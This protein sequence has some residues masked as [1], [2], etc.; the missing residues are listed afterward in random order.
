MNH[1]DSGLYLAS[2][3]EYL[4]YAQSEVCLTSVINVSK[5]LQSL[6]ACAMY[7]GISVFELVIFEAGLLKVLLDNVSYT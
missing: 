7:H 4:E 3:A 2:I 6:T 1:D 5:P